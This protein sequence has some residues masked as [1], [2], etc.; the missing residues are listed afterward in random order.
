MENFTEMENFAEKRKILRKTQGNT[1]FLRERDRRKNSSQMKKIFRK[2]EFRGVMICSS[3]ISPLYI[4][5]YSY[6]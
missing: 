3:H 5:N 1:E 2:G 4:Q 6:L